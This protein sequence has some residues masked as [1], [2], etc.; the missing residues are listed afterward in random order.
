[1]DNYFD[2][3]KKK[4]EDKRKWKAEKVKAIQDYVEVATNNELNE[5]IDLIVKLN[6]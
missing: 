6:K 4:I 1:M 3:I 2:D 5:I